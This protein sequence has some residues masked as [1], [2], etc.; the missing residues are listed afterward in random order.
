VTSRRLGHRTVGLLAIALTLTLLASGCSSLVSKENLVGTWK[1]RLTGYNTVAAGMTQY[2]QTVTFTTD[3]KIVFDTTLPGAVTH[4]T[5]TYEL[6][7][8]DT[9]PIMIIRW[10]IPTDKPS[11]LYYK[12][13][14][15]KLLTTP[16]PDGLAKPEQLNV[17]NADPVVYVK[18]K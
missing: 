2:D 15:G 3:K 5:G 7:K 4:L 8:K 1:T 17:G 6:S 16:S 11:E 12:F 9:N 13:S 18:V 14:N 10:D